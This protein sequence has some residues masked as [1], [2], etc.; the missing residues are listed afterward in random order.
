V[1][2][3]LFWLIIFVTNPLIRAQIVDPAVWNWF[4]MENFFNENELVKEGIEA[5]H[6]KIDEKKDGEIIREKGDFLHYEFDPQGN[7]IESLKSIKLANRVDTLQNSYHYNQDGQLLVKEEIQPPFHFSFHYQYEEDKATKEIKID[8]NRPGKD[9]VQQHFYSYKKQGNMT[10]KDISYDADG[11][12]FKK[13]QTQMGTEGRIE[14]HKLSYQRGGAYQH[15]TFHYE[16][17]RLKKVHFVSQFSAKSEYFKQFFYNNG[18]L[19]EILLFEDGK[20]TKKMALT[21][22]KNGLIEALIERDFQAKQ[23]KIYYFLYSIRN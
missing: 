12:P 14:S 4:E 9:T 16:N 20:R 23:I 19:N 5:I 22:K 17:D 7:L 1:K 8:E 11:L 15:T 10:I 6:I 21:Y 13:E 2:A 18:K 3:L